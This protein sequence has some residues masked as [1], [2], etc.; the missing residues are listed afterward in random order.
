[1]QRE[2]TLND[3]RDAGSPQEAKWP[4]VILD[5]QSGSAPTLR[6][7]LQPF[8]V[9]CLGPFINFYCILFHP[10]IISY[11]MLRTIQ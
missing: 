4:S 1:M 7:C 10:A 5:T 8:S 2:A 3:L 9:A 11:L 6:L